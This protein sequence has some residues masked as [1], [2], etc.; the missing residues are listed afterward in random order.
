MSKSLAIRSPATGMN[1]ILLVLLAAAVIYLI[2][3]RRS[4]VSQYQNKEEWEIVR[5]ARGLATKLI[6]HRDAHTTG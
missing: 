1:T 4:T 6:V 2:M 5:D 3:N